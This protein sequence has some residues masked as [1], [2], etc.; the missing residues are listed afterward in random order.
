M[1]ILSF[2]FSL[3]CWRIKKQLLQQGKVSS[4]FQESFRAGSVF[5]FPLFLL[6]NKMREVP[7]LLQSSHILIVAAY[8]KQV[9]A[10][11]ILQK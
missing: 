8:L 11:M 5:S 3:Q 7:S 9:F 4:N 1:S 6:T 2:E 10:M